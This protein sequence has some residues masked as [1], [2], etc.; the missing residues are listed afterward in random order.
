VEVVGEYE[1]VII[2]ELDLVREAANASQLRS[3]W[4]GSDLIYHPAV[5]FD[6]TS[7][8]VLVMERV[9]GHNID[10]VDAL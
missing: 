10:E 1:K 3:N 9:Y 8:N 7:R 6:Y 4:L 2:D 5:F